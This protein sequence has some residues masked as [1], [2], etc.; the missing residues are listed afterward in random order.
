MPLLYDCPEIT[1]NLA[2]YLLILLDSLGS[3]GRSHFLRK[4]LIGV[5]QVVAS[6]IGKQSTSEVDIEGSLIVPWSRDQFP[7]PG[8]V[9]A[10]FDRRL[11]LA[12]RSLGT[13]AISARK[14]NIA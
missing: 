7:D 1:T 9:L 8:L 11:T 14:S 12:F 5:I 2:A 10:S 4:L 3:S 13:M 6:D